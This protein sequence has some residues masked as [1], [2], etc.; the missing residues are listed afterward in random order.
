MPNPDFIGNMPPKRCETCKLWNRMLVNERPIALGVCTYPLA[1]TNAPVA[2]ERPLSLG[3]SLAVLPD[4]SVCSDW[5]PK[6]PD[7]E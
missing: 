7:S 6:P 5:Q 3:V 2:F 1:G 4:L